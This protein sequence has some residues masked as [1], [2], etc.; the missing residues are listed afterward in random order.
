MGHQGVKN[1]LAEIRIGPGN[2]G[3]VADDL[4][5]AIH[6]VEVDKAHG[7]V[8]LVGVEVA[9]VLPVLHFHRADQETDFVTFALAGTNPGLGNFP[10]VVVT[11]AFF[12]GNTALLCLVEGGTQN[13]LLLAAQT[14]LTTVDPGLTAK[15]GAVEAKT[16]DR[17][18]V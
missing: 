14:P 3:Y 12:N 7:L 11:E 13:L 8:V 16:Q 6:R 4:V 1:A 2:V 15:L 10:G 5:V 9:L 18:S 17:K